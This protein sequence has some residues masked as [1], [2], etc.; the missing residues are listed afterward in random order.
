MPRFLTRPVEFEA[1]RWEGQTFDALPDWFKR[2][3]PP[4][5]LN[6]SHGFLGFIVTDEIAVV[7]PGGWVCR[8]ADGHIYAV[9]DEFLRRVADPI[10]EGAMD[11]KKE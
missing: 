9:T 10:V 2:S 8:S 3:V 4:D 11:V 5:N 1:F 6:L 7:E